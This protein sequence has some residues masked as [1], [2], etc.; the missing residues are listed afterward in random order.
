ML[1]RLGLGLLADPS[2]VAAATAGTAAA[3]SALHSG[4]HLSGGGPRA[5]HV[6]REARASMPACPRVTSEPAL[7]PSRALEPECAPSVNPSYRPRGRARRISFAFAAAMSV[8][9]GDGSPAECDSGDDLSS[10]HPGCGSVGE[11]GDA[12][13]A[14]FGVMDDVRPPKG[15]VRTDW[16]GG[17]HSGETN[18]GS[19]G[20]GRGPGGGGGGKTKRKTGI[21]AAAAARRAAA[22][23]RMQPK[24]GGPGGEGADAIDVGERVALPEPERFRNDVLS[25]GPGGLSLR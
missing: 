11:G 25:R 18:S 14:P 6:G 8:S 4:R 3:A 22:I 17:S 20:G 24:A 16:N 12:V 5:A 23:A 1:A 19:C 21:A 15:R 13:A 9:P 2:L 7:R 10:S